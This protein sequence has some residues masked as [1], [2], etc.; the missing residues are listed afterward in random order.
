MISLNL[1]DQR[2]I[3]EQVKLA[4]VRQIT[5][6]VIAPDEKLPSV[7]ELAA[8]LAINPNTIQKAYAQLESEGYIYTVSGRG[9]FASSDAVVSEKRKAQLVEELERIVDEL[10]ELSISK[11]EI[12]AMLNDAINKCEGG[13]KSDTR[14]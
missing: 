9:S 3:Y 5:T 4:F 7:R 14:K 8:D 13:G 10:M 2:P 6:G 1:R 12:Q 11:E